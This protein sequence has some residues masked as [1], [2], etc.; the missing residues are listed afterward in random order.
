MEEGVLQEEIEKD[1][2][3]NL[4]EEDVESPSQE[5]IQK[6]KSRVL[7]HE[8]IFIQKAEVLLKN[9]DAMYDPRHTLMVAQSYGFK[10]GVLHLLRRMGLYHDIL[11]LHMENGDSENVLKVCKE[12]GPG[13]ANMWVHALSFFASRS[14]DATD[15]ISEVLACKSPFRVVHSLFGWSGEIDS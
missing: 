7:E 13:D 3:G 6:P 10:R 9:P 4:I 5:E 14:G 2:D 11:H 12:Y 15:E 8:T 1:D